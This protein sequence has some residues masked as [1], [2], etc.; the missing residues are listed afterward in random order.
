MSG[1]LL[2]ATLVAVVIGYFLGSLPIAA[3][4]SR[5]AGVDIFEVGTG[6]PGAS[7]VM[8]NVG[9]VPA[10]AVL[11]GDM[12]KGALAI[13]IAKYL[14]VDAPGVDGPLVVLPAG[15]VVLGHW[16]SI[17]T[18]FRG[19]DGLATLG[20]A[21]VALFPIFGIVAVAVAMIVSLGGQKLPY[22]SLLGIVFGYATL[23]LLNVAYDGR[24]VYM[25]GIRDEGNMAAALGIGGVSALVLAHALNGHRRRRSTVEAESLDEMR[26]PDNRGPRPS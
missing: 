22:T 17:F 2:L 5:R 20:G 21:I 24:S 15:A 23:A 13:V 8:R 19:G 26:A 14:G 1:S 16:R 25:M 6:L 4:L 7:N 12:A 9:R 18:R 3:L 11:L 10:V